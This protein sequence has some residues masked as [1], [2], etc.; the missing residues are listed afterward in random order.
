MLPT[1]R[2]WLC[3]HERLDAAAYDDLFVKQLDALLPKLSNPEERRRLEAMRG[4]GWTGY[5]AA[6]LRNAGYREQG[7]V[8]ELT[9]DIVVKLLVAPG[10]LFRGWD[11]RRHGPLDLRFRKSVA[12]AVRN[13]VEK[14]RN[15]RRLLRPVPL[16][17]GWASP[18]DLPDRPE[19]KDDYT[20]ID[21]FRALLQARLG[22]LAAAVFDARLEGRQTKDL[23]GLPDLDRPGRWVVKRVVRQI[24]ALA[25]EYAEALGDPAFLRQVEKLLDAEA[26][27]VARRK[28]TSRRRQARLG[29]A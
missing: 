29:N 7:Q 27:T 18:E 19:R 11:E 2:L 3:L 12:N 4:F 28:A 10:G 25:R 1:F 22:D 24:K 21:G 16:G 26:M 17:T 6:C 9:H 13:A 23:I 15:R 14:D 20:L 8:E 5:I